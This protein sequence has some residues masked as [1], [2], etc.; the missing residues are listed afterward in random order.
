MQCTITCGAVRLCHFVGDFAAVFAVCVVWWTP[1]LLI[2]WHV[3]L[4]A[5]PHMFLAT[6]LLCNM[7]LAISWITLFFLSTASF[8]GGVI[9][10]ENSWD[11]PDLVQKDSMYEFSNSLSSS[12]W[13]RSIFKLFLFCNLVHKVS[14]CSGASILD[15]RR[16]TQVYLVKSFTTTMMYLFPPRDSVLVGP[17]RSGCSSSKV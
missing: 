10:A 17:L 7:A 13:I 1:L 12:F 16:M 11:I 8:C 15:L 3:V 2:V 5:S 14:M 6:S 9:G 4:M